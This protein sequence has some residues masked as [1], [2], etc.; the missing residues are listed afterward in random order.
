MSTRCQ[1][2][3][4]RSEQSKIH[5]PHRPYALLYKH[6]DGYPDHTLPLLVDILA[7]FE[8][9]RGL[10]DDEY[11]PAWVSWFLINNSVEARKETVREAKERGFSELSYQDGISCLGHGLCFDKKFHGDIEFYYRI[12]PEKLHVYEVGFD[13]PPEQWKEIHTIELKNLEKKLPTLI[14]ICQGLDEFIAERMKQ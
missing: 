11:L 2:G 14:G 8:A 12:T 9:R 13:K 4:Y 6:S 3:F 7:K 5:R 1:I 10:D